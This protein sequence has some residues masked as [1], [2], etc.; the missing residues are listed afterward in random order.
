MCKAFV[1]YIRPVI[2]YNSIVWNPTQ[3]CLVDSLENVQRRFTKRVPAISHLNYLER[4]RKINLEPLELRRLKS[5]LINYY[6]FIV[7]PFNP[8]LRK[9]FMFYEPPSSSRSGIPYLQ[10]PIKRSAVSDSSFFYRAVNVWNSLPI[11][12]RQSKSLFSFKNAINKIDFNKFL[13]GSCFKC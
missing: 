4:L 12:V 11:A 10:K 3:V 6:K 9:R 2:E 7:L 5:D 8:E 1:T 13:I